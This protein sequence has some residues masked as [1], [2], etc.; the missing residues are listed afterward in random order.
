[1]TAL[2]C[3]FGDFNTQELLPSNDDAIM[4]HNK[5]QISFS[6][7][8]SSPQIHEMAT[9][10]DEARQE[11][12][13]RIATNAITSMPSGVDTPLS[14]PSSVT[15]LTN[16]LLDKSTYGTTYDIHLRH[17]IASKNPMGSIPTNPNEPTT[18]FKG[19]H[20]F[21]P[22]PLVNHPATSTVSSNSSQS[23][24]KPVETRDSPMYFRNQ[25]EKQTLYLNQGGGN[26][27]FSPAM[28]P[29]PIPFT[30]VQA[31]PPPLP[32]RTDQL[33]PNLSASQTLFP[34][35]VPFLS[36]KQHQPPPYRPPPVNSITGLSSPGPMQPIRTTVLSNNQ[37]LSPTNRLLMMP[38]IEE[39]VSYMSQEPLLSQNSKSRHTDR[40]TKALSDQKDSMTASLKP[41][42]DTQHDTRMSASNALSNSRMQG[43][44]GAISSGLGCGGLSDGGGSHDSH[45]DSGYC[46]GSSSTSG[47]F[48]SGG[49]SP[50]LSGTY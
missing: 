47:R 10:S 42:K 32:K 1:M 17:L 40:S 26:V 12:P 9:V 23:F 3:D 16:F 20:N 50:S 7:I 29:R 18:S 24:I 15:N 49:P 38:P 25:Q 14:T 35:S 37:M 21:N 4:S 39:D 28:M 31:A 22:T 45:N 8:N 43:S 6:S 41:N 5:K 30:P 36:P 19:Y 13:E 46:I 44:Q 33:N 27:A 11:V 2:F 34:S 48:G